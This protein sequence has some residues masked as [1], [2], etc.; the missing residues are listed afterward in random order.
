MVRFE[1]TLPSDG[2]DPE[3][4]PL[5]AQASQDF[6][7]MTAD[8]EHSWVDAT[9]RKVGSDEKMQL[10][11]CALCGLVQSKPKSN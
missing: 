9:A 6:C 10:T 4:E 11:I 8:G 3:F 2:D 5:A 7:P 1:G